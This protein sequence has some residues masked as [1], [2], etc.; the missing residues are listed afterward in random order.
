M[1]I[2]AAKRTN[3]TGWYYRII[4]PGWVTGSDSV[5]LVKRHN[6][7][8]SVARFSQI[9]GAERPN[10][11]GTGG[12]DHLKGVGVRLAMGRWKGPERR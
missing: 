2:E 12:A 3:R 11:E 6:P 4:E 9:L 5:V 7:S 8:W 1:I 10:S